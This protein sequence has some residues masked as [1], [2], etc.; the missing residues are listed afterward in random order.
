MVNYKDEILKVWHSSLPSDTKEVKIEELFK[1]FY[2]ESPDIAKKFE[3]ELKIIVRTATGYDVY[4]QEF[5]EY[6]FN[7]PIYE[8]LVFYLTIG[9]MVRDTFIYIKQQKI[10]MRISV[11]LFQSSGTGKSAAVDYIFALWESL[12]LTVRSLDDFSDAAL[13]GSYDKVKGETRMVHG[14]LSEQRNY[15]FIF[16]DEV[17]GLLVP[18]QYTRKAILY[19]QKALNTIGTKPNELGKDVIKGLPFSIHPKCSLF[20]L[21]FIPPEL[22]TALLKQGLFQRLIISVWDVPLEVYKDN[23]DIIIDGIDGVSHNKKDTNPKPVIDRRVTRMF[24]ETSQFIKDNDITIS[25]MAKKHCKKF[26]DRKLREVEHEA[27]TKKEILC[28]Q[29]ARAQAHWARLCVIEAGHKKTKKIDKRISIQVCGFL[30]QLFDN[31]RV[32][33]DTWVQ[34]ITKEEV[35]KRDRIRKEIVRYLGRDSRKKREVLS[36][37]CKHFNVS[38]ATAQVYIKENTDILIERPNKRDN[39]VVMLSVRV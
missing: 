5:A 28:S 32:Y 11:G 9:Q 35:V 26:F 16:S 12:G 17:S 24:V 6:S 19:F 15:N 22:Q 25:K 31:F 39:R 36:H 27:K 4:R 18:T 2:S 34:D 21:S 3:D 8:R 29:L 38:M 10:D 13:I 37:L 7:N 33:V 20:F 1:Q 23:K 14:V 30:D